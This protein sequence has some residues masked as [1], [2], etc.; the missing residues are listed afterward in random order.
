VVATE[1]LTDGAEKLVGEEEL[2]AITPWAV[3]TT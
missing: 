3:D 2:D 1:A